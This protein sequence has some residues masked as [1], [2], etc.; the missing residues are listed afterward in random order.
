MSSSPVTLT[1]WYPFGPVRQESSSWSGCTA[2][3]RPPR[4]TRSVITIASLPPSGTAATALSRS[5]RRMITCP[6]RLN[7]GGPA[8]RS[9]YCRT[10]TAPRCPVH[11]SDDPDSGS[12]VTTS[13]NNENPYGCADTGILLSNTYEGWLRF[14]GR[15]GI[16]RSRRAPPPDPRRAAAPLR[17][18]VHRL[19]AARDAAG[20]APGPAVALPDAD[21]HA[22]RAADHR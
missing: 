7:V 3:G 16:R 12:R 11:W 19:P 14:N 1:I 22:G 9:A 4:L 5:S 20:P 21:L 15:Q 13:A 8:K 17:G 6:S 10:G 2:A 18:L